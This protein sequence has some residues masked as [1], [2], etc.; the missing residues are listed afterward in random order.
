VKIFTFISQ[1]SNADPGILLNL[2]LQS[3]D[4]D[5]MTTMELNFNEDVFHKVLPEV[6]MSVTGVVGGFNISLNSDF[7]TKNIYL[8]I[9]DEEGFFND[10]YFDMLPGETKTVA[11]FTDIPEA[12]LKD[13]LTLRTLV[14]DL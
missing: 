14:D 11:L 12:K 13:V 8:R 4:P 5:L 7:L 2:N 6:N 1:L 9:A 10:N 3:R